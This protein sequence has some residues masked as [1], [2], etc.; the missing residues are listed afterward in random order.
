MS[1]GPCWKNGGRQVF[2]RR[3]WCVSQ[4]KRKE[5]ILCCSFYLS[6][7]WSCWKFKLV[8]SLSYLS[9]PVLSLL[10]IIL[11]ENTYVYVYFKKIRSWKTSVVSEQSLLPVVKLY[12]FWLGIL[13]VFPKPVA[14]QLFYSHGQNLLG[15]LFFSFFAMRRTTLQNIQNKND[16]NNNNL[17]ACSWPSSHQTCASLPHLLFS[18]MTDPKSIMWTLT[19]TRR[20]H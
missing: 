18:K 16:K 12:K 17:F 20:K 10:W 5:C 19:T 7:G 6:E 2:W 13:Q 11:S 9:K 8:F 15:R 14:D 1:I 3:L 4:S